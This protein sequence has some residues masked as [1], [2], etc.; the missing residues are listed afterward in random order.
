MPNPYNQSLE[1]LFKVYGDWNPLSYVKG[2]DMLDKG[3]KYDDLQSEELNLKNQKTKTMMPLEASYQDLINKGKEAELPGIA[4]TSSLA[5]DKAALSRATLPHQYGNIMQEFQSKASQADLEEMNR[6]GQMF[7]QVGER[8]GY[9]P[10]PIQQ[11]E[12]KRLL[13]RYWLP[14]FEQY[15]PGDLQDTLLN[16]GKGMMNLQP[17][18]FATMQ[19]QDDQQAFLAAEN[20]KKLQAQKE[21][22]AYRTALQ[23]KL[24]NLKASQDPK[25]LEAVIAQLKLAQQREPSDDRKKIIG[26]QIQEFFNMKWE[27][28]QNRAT[29]GQAG[30]VDVPGLGGLPAVAPRVP[31]QVGNPQSAIPTPPQ[32][33]DQKELFTKAFGAYEPDKYDYRIGPNGVPQRKKK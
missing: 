8:I 13:G 19:K 6:A 32:A 4:A 27:L 21:L 3:S 18:P 17:K 30:K 26:E 29:A 12:A 20:A 11:Q 24:A 28:D 5:Q 16:M 10:G 1:G 22:A 23:E 7:A 9:L 33:T 31:P 14:E 2:M 15:S 25:T